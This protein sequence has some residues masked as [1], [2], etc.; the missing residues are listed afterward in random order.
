MNGPL[1]AT[2]VF[3]DC[4]TPVILPQRGL[5]L[6][7][8]SLLRWT[9]D[10]RHRSAAPCFSRDASSSL[11]MLRLRSCSFSDEA[12]FSLQRGKQSVL[13]LWRVSPFPFPLA[14]SELPVSCGYASRLWPADGSC[15]CRAPSLSHARK[16]PLFEAESAGMPQSAIVSASSDTCTG[17]APTSAD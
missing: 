13:C 6:P 9:S 16:S 17:L 12:S 14:V 10:S 3:T 5:A 15:P 8:L 1:S 11:S 2:S 4:L 7:A